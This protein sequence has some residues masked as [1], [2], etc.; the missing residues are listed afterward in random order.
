MSRLL[1]WSV[2]MAVAALPAEAAADRLVVLN[3][4]E[5]EAAIVDP[6]TLKVRAK[7]P[8]GR[9][10]HEVAVSPDGR[11]AYVSD[12]G[13]YNVFKE[14]E[15]KNEPGNTVT[16]LD[17]AR[18]APRDTFD[19]GTYTKPHGIR[20][21]RDGT[22]LWVT[23]EGAKAVLELDAVT[24]A[25]RHVWDTAQEISHMV[26][27]TP[28]ET[29]LYVANIRSGSVTVIDRRSNAVRS[30]ATGGGAEGIDVTPDGREVWVANR[31]ANTVAVIDV[32]SD[33]VEVAFASG[34]TM[35]IRVRITPDGREAWVS[36]A[37]S[38]AV[39]VFD[40][41]TRKLLATLPVGAVPVG[42]E[43]S[44]D[45]KR[46]FVACTNDDVVKVF[47]VR[48]RKVVGDLVTGKEPD[49]M[50]WVKGTAAR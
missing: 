12:Y 10:P 13:Q 23:C 30:L 14:G 28:D 43:M 29:K 50:A 46:A 49:G 27:A 41:G 9:G 26:V 45:G 5:H 47:D 4:S 39:T 35:P 31:E 7:L 25:V 18:G 21:S 40:V 11:T 44:P 34:G 6:A 3:K 22:S 48:A 16:V 17:L 1:S 2:V 42:I 36:N 38:D 33:T 15:R 20:V 24:G 37:K 8:T 19:L 32:A